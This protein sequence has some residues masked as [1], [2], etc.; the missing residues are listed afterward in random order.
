M[1][2]VS[3]RPDDTPAR[4]VADLIRAHYD[5]FNARRLDAAAG[6]FHADARIE[7]ASGQVEY[8]PE[9]F[10]LLARQWLT[11]FPEGRVTVQ[12][13]RAQGANLYEVD[14]VATGTHTGSLAL[15]AWT[16]RPS[17][18]A[19]RL[20][21]RE[22]FHIEAGQIHLASLKL[23]LQ[24]LVRQLATVDIASLQGHTARIGQ[25]GERLAAETDP[26]RQRELI[27]RLGRQL[28]HARHVVRPYFRTGQK[29]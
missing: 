1:H 28:D 22:L 27:D 29:T 11:A 9:G 7:H 10:S 26:K 19:V 2:L 23:D 16:F 3:D 17:H 6:R 18:V 25:L 20:P 12:H 13:L 5:D 24:D 15:G 21:A 4:A 8:G 14:L